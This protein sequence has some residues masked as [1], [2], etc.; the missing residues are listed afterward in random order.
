MSDIISTFMQRVVNLYKS[1]NLSHVSHIKFFNS[2]HII[3]IYKDKVE[4]REKSNDLCRLAITF[5]MRGEDKANNSREFG[6]D[7]S[8]LFKSN[9]KQTITIYDNSGSF[10]ID[11][12]RFNDNEEELLF[13]LSTLS[14]SALSI[15]MSSILLTMDT[16]LNTVYSYGLQ[17]ED[18]ESFS[19]IMG[20]AEEWNTKITQIY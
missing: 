19:E 11:I 14:N 2:K 17:N 5:S 16:E 6:G 4:F 8:Y 13:T 1:K 7:V 12:P 15:L 3:F 18:L 20:M 9:Y 10:E